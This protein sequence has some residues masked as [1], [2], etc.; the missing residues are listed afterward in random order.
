MHLFIKPGRRRMPAGL[1]VLT[2]V[3][4]QSGALAKVP[5]RPIAATDQGKDQRPGD[6]EISRQY[7]GRWAPTAAACRV[8]G[9][10]TRVVEVSSTGWTSFE[11][12]SRV[13][14]PGRVVRG[15]SYHRVRSFAAEG[16]SRPAR[17]ALRLVGS[18]LAMSETVAGRSVHRNLLRCR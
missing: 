8:A 4:L 14:A 13:A 11:E 17:L 6:G 7:R 2:L 10:G 15:T 5:P 18:R 9:P 1:L 3:G 12:G 16:G